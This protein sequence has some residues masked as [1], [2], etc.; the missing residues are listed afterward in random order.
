MMGHSPVAHQ[1]FLSRAASLAAL[2]NKSPG[3]LT[4]IADKCLMAI[5]NKFGVRPIGFR[6]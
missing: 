5:A 4:V 1:G 6:L 3:G 2:W